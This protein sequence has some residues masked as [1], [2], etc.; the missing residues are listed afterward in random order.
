MIKYK[1]KKKGILNT[2]ER[3][4]SGLEAKQITKSGK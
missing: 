3:N 2:D 1:K 4:D